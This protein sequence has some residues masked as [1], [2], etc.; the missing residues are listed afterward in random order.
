MRSR[1]LLLLSLGLGAGLGCGDDDGIVEVDSGPEDAGEPEV[2]AALPP[3]PVSTAHCTY[4]DP[5]STARSGGTV[6]AGTL[7]AGAAEGR[8]SPPVGTALGAYTGRADFLGESS[9]PD[10]RFD[11][12]S[13]AFVPS[14]GI[15]T[16]QRGK[17]LALEA[18]GETVLIVKADLALADEAITHEVARRVGQM[19]GLDLAG[20]VVLSTSHSHSQFAQYTTN[21]ILWVGLGRQRAIVFERIVNDLVTV[22]LEALDDLRPARLGIAHDPNFD[23]E[24]RVTR[25][26][27]P[28]NDALQGGPRD[29]HDLFV[30]RVDDAES[31]AP[32]AVLPV[33]GMHG[34]VLDADNL[35]AST[36]STGGIERVLEE[37]FDERVVVM[38]LQG[39]GGDVSP[40]GTG[41]IACPSR[42]CYDFARVESVGRLAVDAILTAWM[43]AGDNLQS[44]L[45]M[46]MLT[47]HVALGPD[48]NNFVV[49]DGA[50]RYAPMDGRTFADNVV[51]DE[52]GQ[53]ASPID[54]FNAPYGAALC[55]EDGNALFPR[56]QIAGTWNQDHAYASCSRVEAAADILGE[57]IVLPFEPMPSCAT[58][59]T[60]VSAL[61]IGLGDEDFVFVA[62]P[63][64]VN[65]TIAD[66]VR[67]GSPLP[68]GQTVVLGYAQGHVG[69]LLTVEDWLAKGYEPSINV[70]GPL[71]GERIAEQAL[72]VAR[73]AVTDE[74]EDGEVGGSDRYVPR[75]LDDSDVPP[76]DPAPMAGTVE[77]V[78][79]DRLYVRGQRLESNEPEATIPRL[80]SAIF[81][82]MGESP[83]AGTPTITIEREVSEDTW[84]TLRR[85]SGRAVEDQDFL[86]YHTPD[87][88]IPSTP[89]QE[90][91]HR[92]AV[93]WQL[94]TPLGTEGLD[95]LGDRV[96]LAT[97][98]Y[99]FHVVG[100]G[101]EITSRPFEV[102]PTTMELEASVAGGRLTGRARFHAPQGWRLLHL[103]LR[104]N[105]PV[106]ATGD[107]TLRVTT[108][109]GDVEVMATL[110]ADGRFDV[111]VPAGA[112]AV[113]VIDRFGNLGD[114]TF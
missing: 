18:G 61:R 75:E 96:G 64:E 60:V 51:Y 108:G 21:S 70:W 72:E 52:D 47:R 77:E 58:T 2:D 102:A 89:L 10:R 27:R 19:R 94:V 33:F 67:A 29:D 38:H 35:L 110:D 54:E 14:Y 11:E 34:T 48:W 95:T 111:E 42:P 83:R 40:A 93:E 113:R 26:R 63:G 62:L 86:L 87:P 68:Y 103:T 109:E 101:Y 25:D 7:R 74:R 23:P 91:T 30:V 59:R 81:A 50:L 104:S 1:W 13:G 37:R 92:W 5:P 105:E 28:Q 107:V 65:T 24:D 9:S 80:G 97:G 106:P 46:E 85:R 43:D 66:L 71:E 15:E 56:S 114:V 22:A 69:Y 8:L 4:E 20:K 76:P 112:T 32:I 79:Y 17:V 44:E 90:R 88:L 31:G 39:A 36:D 84:E 55:G 99:R 45:S 3:E 82:W 16:R 100:T 12:L 98:R 78:V 6:E 41:G 53:I 57:L 73:L 49:R